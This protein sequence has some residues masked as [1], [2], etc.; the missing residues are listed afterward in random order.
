MWLVVYKDGE[1]KRHLTDSN[2]RVLVFKSKDDA[3]EQQKALP[4]PNSWLVEVEEA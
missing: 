3:N 2:G 1:K 4:H